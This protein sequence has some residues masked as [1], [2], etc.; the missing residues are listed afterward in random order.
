MNNFELVY[1]MKY[2]GLEFLSR[3]GVFYNLYKTCFSCYNNAYPL[4]M[5]IIILNF[6]P[7]CTE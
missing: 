2:P 7:A 4:I 3:A 1:N 6:C 5:V